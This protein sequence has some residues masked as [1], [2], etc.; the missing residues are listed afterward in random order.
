MTWLKSWNEEINKTLAK[1]GVN[2]A[3]MKEGVHHVTSW[4]DVERVITRR[5]NDIIVTGTDKDGRSTTHFIDRG[6]FA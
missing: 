3:M 1:A 5:K 6:F 2:P 4:N